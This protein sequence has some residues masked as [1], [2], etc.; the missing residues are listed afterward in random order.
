M[1]ATEA[2][3]VVKLSFTPDQHPPSSH[4]AI[5]KAFLNPSGDTKEVPGNTFDD[6]LHGNRE[7]ELYYDESP[8]DVEEVDKSS[9]PPA[10]KQFQDISILLQQQGSLT[11]AY[12]LDIFWWKKWKSYTEGRG[13]EPGAIDNWK[14]IQTNPDEKIDD[15]AVQDASESGTKDVKVKNAQK[16]IYNKCRYPVVHGLKVGENYTVV[17]Q[18]IWEALRSWFGGGPPLPRL[19]VS[20][21]TSDSS[22]LPTASATVELDVWPQL[23]PTVVDAMCGAVQE[24]TAEISRSGFKKSKNE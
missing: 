21:V 22:T 9:R 4:P 19:Y 20:S 10:A 15:V 23:I 13:P 16:Y 17:S 24:N 18:Q 11:H 6:K 1:E 2:R 12:L 3:Y 8:M 7:E 5:P 14:I